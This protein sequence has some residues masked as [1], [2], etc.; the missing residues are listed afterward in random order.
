[1]IFNGDSR[2]VILSQVLDRTD[3]DAGFLKK[4]G[5]KRRQR[6]AVPAEIWAVYLLPVPSH[7]LQN[8]HL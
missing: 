2:A 3:Q 8:L 5:F 1:M 4:S 6:G 7:E